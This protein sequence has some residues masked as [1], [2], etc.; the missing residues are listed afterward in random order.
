[1][2][3]IIDF[4]SIRHWPYNGYKP[5][6]E[7][8]NYKNPP[9]II[10]RKFPVVT[11][12]Q[13]FAAREE[14]YYVILWI[15]YTLCT[16]MGFKTIQ[17]SHAEVTS[18]YDFLM[19]VPSKQALHDEINKP[20]SPLAEV[21]RA[22]VQNLPAYKDV[23]L[24]LDEIVNLVNRITDLMI[25]ECHSTECE[26]GGENNLTLLWIQLDRIAKQW[27]FPKLNFQ[28]IHSCWDCWRQATG[29]G[30]DEDKIRPRMF[31]IDFNAKAKGWK[32]PRQN[33]P[34]SR[35]NERLKMGKVK[36]TIERKT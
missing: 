16:P 21:C 31:E 11:K 14:Y 32:N 3:E 29:I 34:R 28:H 30:S 13:L 22:T 20:L 6:M 5:P 33:D 23:S 19:T 17:L 7:T 35:H 12:H 15:R 10:K 24:L 2:S 36:T 9:E 27:D 26:G 4:Y 25:S 8:L 18:L 1:M